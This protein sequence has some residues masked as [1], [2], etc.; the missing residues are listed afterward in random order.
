MFHINGF[1][2]PYVYL[3][4]IYFAGF[5]LISLAVGILLGKII[6]KKWTAAWVVIAN[7]AIFYFFDLGN[8][9]LILG[10]FSVFVMYLYFFRKIS[11]K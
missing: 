2:A 8:G 5:I 7:C 3:G 6:N 10:I 11:N 9:S 4:M 1:F